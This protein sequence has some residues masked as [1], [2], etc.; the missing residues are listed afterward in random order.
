MRHAR[1]R[2]PGPAASGV[3]ILLFVAMPRTAPA[4]APWTEPLPWDALA[5]EPG[6]TFD[7]QRFDDPD[8]G[9]QVDAFGLTTVVAQGAANRIYL[10]WR[11]LSFH[12]DGLGVMAR[13]SEV[14]P[15]SEGDDAVD[16]DWPGESSIAGWGRP[17]IGLLA[18]MRLP[19]VG[20]SVFCG[21]VAL[22]FA[23][24]DLYPFAA[25]STSLRFALRRTFRLAPGLDGA[26]AHERILNMGAAGEDLADEAF[27]EQGAWSGA[28]ACRFTDACALR[29]TV[30]DAGDEDR[31]L[32]LVLDL[33]LGGRR[34]LS[35]GATR[36]LGDEEDRL[37]AN[38]FTLALT[39]G[40]AAPPAD[41][42]DAA[43]EEKP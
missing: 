29:L 8:S 17:E 1:R 10:R 23:R 15:P 14:A 9:W 40:K 3:L 19:L 26:L 2:T 11:H 7:A 28:L 41:D 24:N 13:W 27:P 5:S 16:T 12:T 37:F 25:R 6:F 31:R 21:E 42:P 4:A 38:R 30:R 34:I 39:I 43:H 36:A 35:L 32:R 33:P 18:P 20:E 22:P